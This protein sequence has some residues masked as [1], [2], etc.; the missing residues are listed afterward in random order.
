MLAPH[1]EDLLV[2]LR[3]DVGGIGPR[4]GGISL[5]PC[6]QG[7]LASPLVERETADAE[8][9]ARRCDADLRSPLQRL[10]SLRRCVR[11][12]HSA[13][14]LAHEPQ[15]A[16][17]ARGAGVELG[18]GPALEPGEQGGEQ[19][20]G[21]PR[22]ARR[23]LEPR[24]QAT[25]RGAGLDQGRQ[26]DGEDLGGAQAQL[27]GQ[28]LEGRLVHVRG[29][30]PDTGHRRLALRHEQVQ[31]LEDL[32]GEIL[33]QAPTRATAVTAPGQGSSP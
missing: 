23:L 18:H 1:R 22:A 8:F 14:R 11:F 13:W 24:H 15:Q 4:P 12:R 21:G 5:P 7:D 2:A 20:Q 19:A 32:D 29:P 26:A 27:A 6:R 17:A 16:G 30:P 3:L 31:Q 10:R 28:A 25:D 33:P 9:L